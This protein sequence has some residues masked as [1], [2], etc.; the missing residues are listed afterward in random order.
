MPQFSKLY[1]SKLDQELGTDDRI[2]FT[3]ARRKSA[4]NLGLL[5]FADLTECLTR[6]STVTSSHG[7]R[8][9]DLLSTVQMGGS[10]DFLRLSKQGPEYHFTDTG[11]H[12]T[13][14]AGDQFP[15]RDIPWLNQNQS[16]WR[17]STAGTPGCYYERIDGGHRY[18]GVDTP[19]DIDSTAGESGQFV[20]PYVAKPAVL[21]SDTDVPFTVG[22]VTRSDLEPFHQGAVHFAAS[23]LE[24]LR[25]NTEASQMQLQIAL[26]YVQRFVQTF[27]PKGGTQMRSVKSYFADARR[28]RLSGDD[29]D[30]VRVS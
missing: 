23:E 26:G 17:A 22:T 8:E 18:F 5:Q 29:D 11:G 15:R 20:I 16:G 6:Q 28:S 21:T 12:V 3:A 2:L 25:V 14:V 1:S 30:A 7:V 10:S 27:R 19:P 4:I 9:Y 13:Y 24:K